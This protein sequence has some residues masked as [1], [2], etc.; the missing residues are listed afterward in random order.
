M[1][2]RCIEYCN[3]ALE[4]DHRSIKALFRRA[5]AYRL[6]DKVDEAQADLVQLKSLVCAKAD[7]MQVEREMELLMDC[8][9]DYRNAAKQFA[10]R[11]MRRE[12]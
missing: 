3:D 4:I 1:H 11:A 10:C 2:K 9:R 12:I 7:K 8:R 5:R 6:Q